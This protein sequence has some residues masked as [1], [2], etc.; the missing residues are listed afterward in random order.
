MVNVLHHFSFFMLNISWHHPFSSRGMQNFKKTI[1]C[2][3]IMVLVV[4]I[5]PEYRVDLLKTGQK[6]GGQ[7]EYCE[8]DIC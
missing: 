6:A 2:Y 1:F 7:N 5:M 4:C 8:H 3:K